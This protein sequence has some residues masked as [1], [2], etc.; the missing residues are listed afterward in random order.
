MGGIYEYSAASIFMI[1]HQHSSKV[2]VNLTQ[3]VD[4]HTNSQS[5]LTTRAFKRGKRKS[6]EG[7]RKSVLALN[8]CAFLSYA[9]L[10]VH[11]VTN[12]I[13]FIWRDTVASVLRFCSEKWK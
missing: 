4:W 9:N 11:L 3:T 13:V 8:M 2:N 10:N 6:S 1:L 12:I 5:K 7:Q